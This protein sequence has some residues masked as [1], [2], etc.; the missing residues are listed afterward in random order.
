[1]RYGGSLPTKREA[2]ERKGWIADELAARRVPDLAA[3]VEPVRAPTLAEAAE[4]WQ[5]S[6]STS[7]T[8]MRLGELE[9]LSWGD[10]DEQ[11]GRWRVSKAV[12]KTRRAR[13]ATCL[14]CCSRPSRRSVA[15][16]D[17][18]RSG[19][20]FQGFGGDRFRT[21]IGRACIAAGVPAFSPHDLRHRRK[22]RCFT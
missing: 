7:A 21:A 9:G 15:R 22:S 13:W 6:P 3:F 19:G 2:L 11:R 16:D 10:V 8:G 12:S 5:P 14:R 17:R 4:R 20:N 1:M 18:T